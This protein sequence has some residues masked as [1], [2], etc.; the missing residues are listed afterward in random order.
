MYSRNFLR[1]SKHAYLVHL[2]HRHPK[3]T[4]LVINP[5]QDV[6]IIH[7]YFLLSFCAGRFAP[8]RCLPVLQRLG[9]AAAS[10]Q[11]LPA[12]SNTAQRRMASLH[13]PIASCSYQAPRNGPCRSALLSRN[14]S[15]NG[16]SS[17]HLGRFSSA[18]T[19]STLSNSPSI[20][21]HQPQR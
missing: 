5:F 12:A 15:L 18:L 16:M 4:G 6:M 2:L 13:S 11:A 1:V 7:T 21:S 19:G 10:S 14:Q 3:T 20:L 9:T 8:Q 17:V